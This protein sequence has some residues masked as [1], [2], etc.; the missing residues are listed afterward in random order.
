VAPP[1]AALLRSLRPDQ[2]HIEAIQEAI[3][4][5]ALAETPHPTVPGRSRAIATN[6]PV[7]HR[8]TFL[9]VED[10]PDDEALLARAYAD[11][12]IEA[13]IAVV[14][15]GEEALRWLSANR[16]VGVVLLDLNLPGMHGF[17]V[18]EFAREDPRLKHVPIVVFTSSDNPRDVERAYALGATSY[19]LKPIDYQVFSR[20]V[21]EVLHYWLGTNKVPRQPL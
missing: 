4:N 9:L 21:R 19:V 15:D 5:R 18:L 10:S 7:R 20:T 2:E 8:P 3:R 12:G 16:D 11:A 6:H 17:E 13:S 1:P 14:R